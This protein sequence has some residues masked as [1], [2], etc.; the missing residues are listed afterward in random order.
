MPENCLSPEE[1]RQTVYANTDKNPVNTPRPGNLDPAPET[2]EQM[3][4]EKQTRAEREAILDEAANINA[5]MEAAPQQ[6]TKLDEKRAKVLSRRALH[7]LPLREEGE[8]GRR[9]IL[10][11]FQHIAAGTTVAAA[12]AWTTFQ[13]YMNKMFVTHNAEFASW[14][15]LFARQSDRPAFDNTL[16]QEFNGM[17]PRIRGLNNKFMRDNYAIMRKAAAPILKKTGENE[18]IIFAVAGDWLNARHMPE[19]NAHLLRRWQ[20]ELDDAVAIISN[21]DLETKAGRKRFVD[22]QKVLDTRTEW[23]ANLEASINDTDLSLR[24]R[25]GGYT[26]GQAQEVMRL[27][28]ERFP[29]VTEAEWDAAARALSDQFD[30]LTGEQARAGVI[31]QEHIEAIPDFEWYAP[32]VS[33]LVNNTGVVNDATHYVPGARHAM[34]GMEGH[35]DNAWATLMAATSRTATEIGMQ[36]LGLHLA[37]IKQHFD[38][39]KIDAGLREWSYDELMKRSREGALEDRQMA[40][41]LLNN[42][43]I[44]VDMP[45]TLQNGESGYQK[46]YYF[47]DE[48]WS[49]GNL[50]GINLNKALTGTYKIGSKPEQL[51]ATATSYVGQSHTRFSPFFAPVAMMRDGME[52]M[53][54][55]ASR[56]YYDASGRE[57][58]GVSL[59]GSFIGN[60]NKALKTLQEN[61]R[62]RLDAGSE[63]GRFFDEYQ[64]SGL[65]QKFTPGQRQEPLTLQERLGKGTKF[66]EALR[67]NQLGGIA[68]KIE[69]SKELGY[70]RK[71][72]NQ[73]GPVGRKALE[74]LDTWNDVLQNA[75]SFA[76]YITMRQ[77]G[78]NQRQA[79]A[80][81]L[82]LMNMSQSG[83]VATHLAA[84]APFVRPTMQGA[85]V[86]VQAMGLSGRNPAEILKYGKKGWAAGVT[87]AIGYSVLYPLIRDAMGF[88]ENGKS[89]LDGMD[90][91]KLTS[92]TPI[93][94]GDGSY[95]KAPSGFG[96]QRVA[97]AAALVM[98]RVSRGIMDPAEGAFQLLFA[99]VRDVV[100]G[101]VPQFNIADDPSKW[102]MSF[103]TPA[104]MKPFAENAMNINFF[105][106]PVYNEY[107]DSARS[108]SEMGRRTTPAIWHKVARMMHNTMGVDYPPEAYMHI[109]E[110]MNIGPLRM[111]T[112]GIV[113]FT[114]IGATRQ[115]FDKP[116]A[117]EEI[118][119]AI[120]PGMGTVA[121][122]LGATLWYGKERNISQNYYHKMK[123]ALERQVKRAGVRPTQDGK[124]G[125]EGDA[126]IRAKLEDAGLSDSIINDYMLVRSAEK[127]LRG[128]GRK[129]TEKHRYFYDEEDTTELKADF[130]DI[131]DKSEEVYNRVIRESN[132]YNNW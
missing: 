24:I 52:R 89:I 12:S 53:F 113:N 82:Q 64:R 105:G 67:K 81:T 1:A 25:S 33:N 59:L 119:N 129:W 127:E 63:L 66:T 27:I 8:T 96:A 11:D 31:H 110:G 39:K 56:S 77:K 9:E 106:S 22:A 132:Y 4:R 38:A 44:V 131:A 115:G 13:G 78:F 55:M 7:W 14:A 93:P 32:Q 58:K 85:K 99:S 79:A 128:F 98:D 29:T 122:M 15:D 108:M 30:K 76:Q 45:V 36:N 41:R 130:I 47:F 34:Q 6:P 61:A 120:G 17:T 92:F 100:P 21:P 26:N 75:P 60:T 95:I 42:G 2:P 50:T 111:L 23:I 73:A 91:A 74:T 125:A 101:A 46:R 49:S 43:G 117:L 3:Y 80:H 87:A 16:V 107:E 72:M 103:L 37:A 102:I 57:V 28:K 20:Q 69:N 118:E 51:L 84:I 116:T 97:A 19:R 68:D 65:Y 18:N 126:I 109:V 35:P 40:D 104:P 124:Q 83:T 70:L 90:V 112:S 54:Q 86:L 88:D 94:I 48:R 10:Q 121:A 114:K 62:G 71:A 5:E 123:D